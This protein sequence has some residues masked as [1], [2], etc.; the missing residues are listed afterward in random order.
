ML[1]N[2]SIAVESRL[3]ARCFCLKKLKISSVWSRST[4]I[5]VT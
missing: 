2:T 5:D 1:Y 3:E 4:T